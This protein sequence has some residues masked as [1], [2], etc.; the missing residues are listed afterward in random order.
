VTGRARHVV[1]QAYLG[2]PTVR[3]A[4]PGP[5]LLTA[6]TC[7]ASRWPLLPWTL[8]VVD[9]VGFHTWLP[10][11]YWY[12]TRGTPPRRAGAL[13]VDLAAQPIPVTRTCHVLGFSKQAFY[14][15]R[16]DPISQRD[17]DDAHLANAAIDVHA[18][19]PAFG[20]RLIH[21]ELTLTQGL[22]VGRNRVARLCREQR[23]FSV[24]VK[25]RGRIK[26]AG[27][28]VH[29][30]HVQRQFKTP[31]L[32]QAWF[33]DSVAAL[34]PSRA[35]HERG[36][37]VHVR[38]QGRLLQPDRGP[39]HGTANDLGPRLQRAALCHHRPLTG[40]D[41]RELRQRRP[42]SP[43]ALAALRTAG[44]QDSIASRVSLNQSK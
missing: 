35:L 14:A 17:W 2:V 38:D 24:I 32:D 7:T 31:S 9:A 12:V 30:G 6:L 15:W 19:D 43:R 42:V 21:D 33:T 36:E 29:D 37:A 23:V 18:D 41:E 20:Y 3:A 27:P 5:A 28:V 22:V 16:A 8:T 26:V 40:R 44:S 11:L 1:T 34:L 13:Q 4:G 25:R 10:T 39:V